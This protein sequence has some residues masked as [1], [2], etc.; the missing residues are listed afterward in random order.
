MRET[1]FEQ[2]SLL[3][4]TFTLEY[5]YFTW[6]CTVHSLL[7]EFAVSLLKT[8]VLKCAF[9]AFVRGVLVRK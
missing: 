8:A 6:S 4:A 7:Y 2:A 9:L 5:N 1:H 3:A